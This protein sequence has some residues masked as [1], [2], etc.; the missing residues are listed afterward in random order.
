MLLEFDFRGI[1][2]IKNTPILTFDFHPSLAWGYPWGPRVRRIKKLHKSKSDRRLFS[3]GLVIKNVEIPKF[4]LAPQPAPP[5][6]SNFLGR[7]PK[8]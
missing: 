1:L 8:I 7:G 2:S 3:G 6:A 4:L 5:Y